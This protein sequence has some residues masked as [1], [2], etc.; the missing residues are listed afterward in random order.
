MFLCAVAQ[1]WEGLVQRF[2]NSFKAGMSVNTNEAVSF[3]GNRRSWASGL[4]QCLCSC[5][6]IERSTADMRQHKARGVKR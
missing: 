3:L 1:G 4:P 5:F 6:P 2:R